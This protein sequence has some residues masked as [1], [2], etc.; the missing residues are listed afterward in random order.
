MSSAAKEAL[1]L[2]VLPYVAQS[3]QAVG[4]GAQKLGEPPKKLPA[5][6]KSLGAPDPATTAKKPAK[7]LTRHEK[8]LQWHKIQERELTP[9]EKENMRVLA[10]RDT[11]DTTKGYRDLGWDPENPPTDVLF[12]TVIE[13]AADVYSGRYTKK[14]RAKSMME[15]ILT[16]DSVVYEKFKKRVSELPKSSD[17]KRRKRR[18]LPARVSGE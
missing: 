10:M 4:K 2:C 9:E 14:Q 16:K 18:H 3:G 1:K 13:N 12:G 15:E 8:T 11:I 7:H 17:Q 5:A 6:W